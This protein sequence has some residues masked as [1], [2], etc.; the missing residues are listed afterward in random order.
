MGGR[1]Y[2]SRRRRGGRQITQRP[3]VNS[4]RVAAP[5][6]RS[7]GRGAQDNPKI[8]LRAA[9]GFLPLPRPRRVSRTLSRAPALAM[10][11]AA[12]AGPSS[13]SEAAA[14]GPSSSAAPAATA[15]P[16]SG[17][18]PSAAA[19]A[20]PAPVAPRVQLLQA[21][22]LGAGG[23]GSGSGSG[24]ARACRHH[25]YSRKQKSLGLLCSK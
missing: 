18:E 11:A 4:R 15:R 3:R 1:G 24:D 10:D 8:L 23:A 25:A 2:R 12:A 17:A 7:T 21:P 14:A 20:Q 22:L 5:R 19:A 16:S 13:S 6:R 9:E